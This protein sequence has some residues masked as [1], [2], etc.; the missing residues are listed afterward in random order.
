MP[1]EPIQR[2]ETQNPFSM[3]QT[4]GFVPST[5]PDLQ[6]RV[7]PAQYQAGPNIAEGLVNSLV[8]F[9][10]VSADQYVKRVNKEVAADKVVQTAKALRKEA[11]TSD[12]TN[13]GY[14]AH[15]AIALQDQAIKQQL[16]LNEVAKQE[17]TDEEWDDEVRKSYDAV[18]KYMVDNYE[19]YNSS[20]ELQK[21]AGLSLREVIPQ[22]TA[23]RQEQALK[24]EIEGRISTATDSLI[25][26]AN[27]GAYNALGGAE[28]TANHIVTMMK[29][30]QLTPAQQDAVFID[31]IENSRSPELIET[32]KYWKGSRR[33]TLYNR[34][35]RIQSLERTLKKEAMEK[36][37]FNTASMKYAMETDFIAGNVTDE[38]MR[39]R[40]NAHERLT[41][42]PLFTEGEVGSMLANRDKR[43]AIDTRKA[44]VL[45]DYA[46]G[47]AYAGLYKDKE[48]QEAATTY[49]ENVIK[50]ITNDSLNLPE[51][52]REQYVKTKANQA[53]SRIADLSVRND[54]LIESWKGDLHALATINVPAEITETKDL[55]PVAQSALLKL[56]AMAPIT[57]ETYIDSLDS[58]EQKILRGYISMRDMNV[59]AIQALTKSQV[60]A[61]NPDPPDNKAIKKAVS[62]VFD[63]QEA[64]LRPDF[65]NAQAGYIRDK[66]RERV[67]LFPEPSSDTNI[68][69]VNEWFEKG[70]TVAGKTR[71]YGSPDKLRSLTG[72]HPERLE[73]AMNGYIHANA[74]LLAKS[75]AGTDLGLKDV[76]PE[77]DPIKGTVTLRTK[78]GALPET[79]MPLSE[80]KNVANKY[81]VK[82]E[83]EASKKYDSYDDVPWS[84]DSF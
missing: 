22:A 81:K 16:R 34:S 59:P 50:N 32:S 82:L 55:P 66:I 61:R 30:L 20:P 36:D 3:G 48:I 14:Q 37:I 31:A 57:R 33:S 24:R 19:K 49:T 69:I 21:L 13:A 39:A 62:T 38:E 51:N 83:E 23:A 60:M 80:L 15:A 64:W 5:K 17:L 27:T 54:Q 10:D 29:S 56:D 72:L 12:A 67:A 8:Q 73:T 44:Q 25:N 6:S 18:D 74:D 78:W 46:Q 76:F 11:P 4:P 75:L 77:T 1:K 7:N 41:G 35:G 9:A 63:K 45:E 70:W 40:S 65:T 2:W 71:L 79:T 42:K 58:K 68:K 28:G 52:Q 43:I 53:L 47:K 26:A 84:G